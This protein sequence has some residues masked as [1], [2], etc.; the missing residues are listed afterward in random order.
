M[1]K[2]V[3][4]IIIFSILAAS[5]SAVSQEIKISIRFYDKKIYYP[6]SPIYIKTEIKNESSETFRFKAADLRVF[7]FE[8]TAKTLTNLDLP[9]SDKFIIDRNS[10]QPVFFRE[11]SLEPGEEYAFIDELSQ[12]VNVDKAGVFILQSKFFPELYNPSRENQRLDSNVLSLS[13]RP[14]PGT[15]EI[16]T[17][18]D[19]ETGIILRKS[20]L[21]PDEVVAYTISARQKSQWEKFFLYLDLE[22]LMLRNPD[23]KRQYIRLSDED[24]HKMIAQYKHDLKQ[25]TT[26][27]SILLIPVEFEILKTQYTMNEGTVKVIERFQYPTYTEIKE[28]TYY[29]RRDDRIWVIY[30]YEVQNKGTE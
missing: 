3:I 12:Y 14:V 5:L 15:S 18:I 21:P 23:R 9:L 11:I 6:D 17:R 1:K 8:F 28:Y 4:S 7:N 10:D 25:N 24:R 16:Q 26:D 2:I 27:T 22:S 20:P 30:S 13:V 29:L 19:E